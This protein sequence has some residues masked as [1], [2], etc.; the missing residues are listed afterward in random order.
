MSTPM[1]TPMSSPRRTRTLGPNG[2]RLLIPTYSAS[3]SASS[4]TTSSP[5]GTP[6]LKRSYTMP[7]PEEHVSK[8]KKRFEE[9]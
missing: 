7:L 4:S 2:A 6:K 9:G 3:S 8:K 1:S 5:V